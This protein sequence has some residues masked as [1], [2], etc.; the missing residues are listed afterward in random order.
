MGLVDVFSNKTLS[1]S[2]IL[3]IKFDGQE[4]AID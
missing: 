3:T 1:L 2:E 4:V